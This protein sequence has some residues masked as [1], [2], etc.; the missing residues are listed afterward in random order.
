MLLPKNKAEGSSKLP[1]NRKK[2]KIMS[3]DV[4][5]DVVLRM[6]RKDAA[7]EISEWSC[8]EYSF[9]LQSIKHLQ[10]FHPEFFPVIFKSN[11]ISIIIFII[12]SNFA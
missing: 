8:E 7:I 5:D 12:Y 4:I 6:L 1:Q 9:S 10:Y 2:K 11:Q 3:N